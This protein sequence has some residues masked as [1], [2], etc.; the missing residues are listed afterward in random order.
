MHRM[1]S[2]NYRFS[3]IFSRYRLFHTKAFKL[4]GNHTKMTKDNSSNELLSLYFL[5]NHC[6][7]V[8]EIAKVLW[9]TSD[10]M[11]AAVSIKK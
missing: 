10:A 3:R 5:F 4:N 7:A 11:N 2:F 1:I 9:T 6:S 8:K